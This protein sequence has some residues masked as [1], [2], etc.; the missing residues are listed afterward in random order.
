M[1]HWLSSHPTHDNV[2]GQQIDR[3]LDVTNKVHHEIKSTE[4]FPSTVFLY[5][6]NCKQKCQGSNVQVL[7]LI[8]ASILKLYC[9]PHISAVEETLPIHNSAF[10]EHISH[11]G[12]QIKA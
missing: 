2:P 4:N 10:S 3:L 12:F 7:D 5:M 1:L 9:Q 6:Q 11:L 8:M